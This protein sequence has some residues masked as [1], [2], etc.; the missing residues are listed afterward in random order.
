MPSFFFFI[1]N[2]SGL[3]LMAEVRY[4][5][6]T[7]LQKPTRQRNRCD[8]GISRVLE[9][10]EHFFSV[11]VN[12]EQKEENRSKI[13]VLLP[14]KY[15]FDRLVAKR[16]INRKLKVDFGLNGVVFANFFGGIQVRKCHVNSIFSVDQFRPPS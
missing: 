10:R 13:P 2:G 11:K 12:A 8:F 15:N 4:R 7:G 6:T 1:L 16:A 9:L 5:L 3:S 14:K